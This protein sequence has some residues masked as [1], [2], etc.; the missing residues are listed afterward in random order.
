MGRKNVTRVRVEINPKE[1]GDVAFRKMFAAFKSACMDARIIHTYKQHET[2]ESK[3]MKKRRKKRES[4]IFR[5]KSKLKE[6]FINS[7]TKGK[8]ND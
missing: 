8:N 5:L 7:K 3:S 1:D 6:N 2:Y 4:E